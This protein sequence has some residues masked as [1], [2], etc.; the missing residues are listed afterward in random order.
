MVTVG[1]ALSRD[2]CCNTMRNGESST[3]CYPSTGSASPRQLSW[4][5]RRK[6]LRESVEFTAS[7]LD[8]NSLVVYT[9]VGGRPELPDLIVVVAPTICTFPSLSSQVVSV[10]LEVPGLSL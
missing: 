1:C 2:D 10:P 8:K 3:V 6:D 5:A 9:L 7:W 4:P